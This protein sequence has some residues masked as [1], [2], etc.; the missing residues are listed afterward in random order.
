MFPAHTRRSRRSKGR[1]AAGLSPARGSG[2]AGA[3]PGAERERGEPRWGLQGNGG[4]ETGGHG[5]GEWRAVIMA[6]EH[7]GLGGEETHLTQADVL[8]RAEQ[9]A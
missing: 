1:G 6:E 3:A 9:E 4:C 7:H 5:G 2:G 8:G